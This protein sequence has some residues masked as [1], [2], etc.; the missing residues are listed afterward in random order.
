MKEAIC[1]LPLLLRIWC[2]PKVENNMYKKDF[3]KEWLSG[4][5]A[6]YGW[7][8]DCPANSTPELERGLRHKFED[9]CLDKPTSTNSS[10]KGGKRSQGTKKLRNT[11]DQ[12]VGPLGDKLHE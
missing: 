6:S 11:K 3:L 1:C 12:F 2:D 8:L 7:F 4:H 5:L 9:A 10:F